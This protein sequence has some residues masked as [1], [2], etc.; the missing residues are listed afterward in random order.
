MKK[1]INDEVLAKILMQVIKPAR[2]IGGEWNEIKKDPT[3]AEVKIALAFP[4]TYEL[5]MSSIGLRIL[6]KIINS[7]PHL[8]A[9]RVF[10]PWTDL[11]QKLRTS[12]LPLYSLENKL[13]LFQFDIIG[14]SLLY[15]LNFTNVLTMLDLGG[16]RLFSAE[17]SAKDPL[18]IAGGPSCFNPEPLVDF[19]DAFFIGD[20][21]EAILEIISTYQRWQEKGASRSELLAALAGIKGMYVPRFYQ[22]Q[23]QSLPQPQSQGQPKVQAQTQAQSNFP[24]LFV[25][26]KDSYP[27]R[28]EKRIVY[29]LDRVLYPESTLVPSTEIVFDRVQV[30]IARG[31]PQRCRFCQATSLYFPH[32]LRS[33]EK[34][35]NLALTNLECS[36]YDEV[37]LTALSAS[38]YPYLASLVR[39][40]MA[41]LLPQKIALSFPSLRPGGVSKD[42]VDSIIKVRK[43][44]LTIV[45]EAGT[46]RLRRVINKH[47][48]DEEIWEAARAAFSRGWRLLK[49]YFMVGLPTEKEEDLEG[50]VRI[51]EEILKIGVSILKVAPQINLSIS[52]FIPKPHTPFQW[53]A[54]ESPERLQEKIS[55]L[56][57]RLRKYPTV[58]FK[59]HPVATS[60][61]EAVISRGDRRVGEVIR[62]AWEKGARFDSWSDTFN[63]EL[64]KE[65]F[66]EAGLD[67]RVYLAKIPLRAKLPWEHIS[68]G[69]K[70]KALLQ[71]LRRAY[72]EERTPSCSRR[73]CRFCQGCEFPHLVN[74]LNQE[75]KRVSSELEKKSS[76]RRGLTREE[77]IKKNSSSEVLGQE[78][79][80]KKSFHP[81]VLSQEKEEKKSS[82]LRALRQEELNKKSSV[83]LDLGREEL[84][85]KNLS[86][87][88]LSPEGIEKK[89]RNNLI[90]YRFYFEKKGPARFLSHLDLINTI[91]RILRRAGVAVAFSQGYHPKMK[92][93]FLPALPLGMTSRQE[94]FE[95]QAKGPLEEKEVVSK[96]NKLSPPGIV[97]QEIRKVSPQQPSLN[98]EIKAVLYSLEAAPL[99]RHLEQAKVLPG[100]EEGECAVLPEGQELIMKEV[101]NLL[102]NKKDKYSKRLD[103]SP[104]EDKIYFLYPVE[105]GSIGNP[106]RLLQQLFDWD[107]ASFYLTREKVYFQD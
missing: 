36:G 54:M 7:Q 66:Q 81:G 41:S 48:S 20:G 35:K 26:P 84:R 102:K 40:M 83:P 52:S 38:D 13:P 31:C 29:D 69:F 4:D 37:A 18:V 6:Y 3:S 62:I 2:Y 17:R 72:R 44:G 15:E 103:Y 25:E 61:L 104:S 27:A 9:E 76:F 88:D 99:R 57:K 45:P 14:F 106:F 92:L 107:Q 59:D 80:E 39:E 93:T 55:F 47:L 101:V 78:E 70:K 42:I 63:F 85:E 67:Y 32:R 100:I 60:V 77:L 94:I 53:E 64:W 51:V 50:I 105:K 95:L 58:W 73:D 16:I 34:V 49:L 86:G 1:K 8:L 19:I 82:S 12:K 97:F 46:E 10:A 22:A 87:A 71:E 24:L 65:S 56:K 98:R 96:L 74:K 23:A 21:E 28:I 75:T 5:G 30:E 43:T 91:P 11:E 33:L 89:A 68:S 79:I 90:R